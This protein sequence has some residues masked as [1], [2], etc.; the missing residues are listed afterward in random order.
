MKLSLHARHE[1]HLAL[2]PQMQQTIRL[3]HLSATE[4][5]NDLTKAADE[6]PLLE[7]EARPIDES[8][9]SEHASSQDPY[10]NSWS[11]GRLAVGDDDDLGEGYERGA[12]KQSL[13]QYLQ[14]QINL[15]TI[16]EKEKGLISYLAGCLDERGYLPESL[17]ELEPDVED[18]LDPINGSTLEQLSRAL[19]LL[20]SLDPIGIGARDLSECLLIQ[21]RNQLQQPDE[22]Y[23]LWQIAGTIAKDHLTKVAQR[24]WTKLRKACESS[25]SEIFQAVELIRG[26]HPI[27]AAGFEAEDEQW[28]IPEVIVKLKKGI[29]IVESNPAAQ[30]RISLNQEY[31]KILKEHDSLKAG[32]SLHQKMQEARWLIKNVK[33]R[34]ETIFRV[35]NAIV[36]RQ[37]NFFSKGKIGMNPLV[38]KEIAEELGFHESTISRVTNQKYLSCPFG[39]IEFKFFF[40]HHLASSHG[41]TIS[42]TAVQAL[43]TKIVNT[44]PPKKPISD[45]NIAKLLEDQG[46]VIARRTVTKYREAMRIPVAHLRKS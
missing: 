16:S 1:Q 26:L 35:A 40:S 11:G 12:Q 25:E 27:P 44:E 13:L 33:Q 2:T 5:E 29:W 41:E 9:I 8:S 7:L 4:L 17:E 3:L 19:R 36:A 30:T 46:Y 18:L 20:Q 14:E 31:L 6:N 42:S 38:L 24:D 45:N 43:I 22:K 32:G 28:V 23:S 21:I 15:F 37:Q 10:K 39:I 34:E